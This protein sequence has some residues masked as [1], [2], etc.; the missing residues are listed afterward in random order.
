MRRTLLALLLIVIAGG[1][2]RFDAA[3]RPSE[4]QSK[5]EQSYAIIARTI[6]TN[7][8]YG[9]EIGMED[10]VHWVPGAPVFFSVAYHLAGRGPFQGKPDIPAAYK[11]QAMAG[12]L[13]ILASF[14]LGLLIAGRLAGL[15]GAAV[16]AF[17][18]PLIAASGDLLSEPLG[19][20]LVTSALAMTVWAIRD[21][22]RR[23]WRA[24]L[25]GLLLGATVL[26]RADLALVPLIAAAAVAV[27][28]ALATTG[29]RERTFAGLRSAAPLV[30]A[31]LVVVTPWTI[32]AS[33]QA[34]SFVPLSHG[35]GS[36]LFVGTYL[37]GDGALFATKKALIP[38]T[39][40]RF[41]ELEE[42]KTSYVQ[43]RSRD[44]MKA[45][46]L[47]R[48]EL[49]EEAALK[50]EGFANLRRYALGDPLGF[51]QMMVSKV[52]RL[53]GGYSVGTYGNRRAPVMAYHLAIVAI[54]FAGLLAGLVLA[55]R[56]VLLLPAAALLYISA[57]NAVLVSESR[58]NLTLIPALACA[59]VGGI[60]LTVRELRAHRG[61][62]PDTA[63]AMQ[64]SLQ[65][66]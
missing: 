13:L 54:G 66:A 30:G 32:F 34:G 10:P 41:P 18:P 58:H 62:R 15:L 47:R 12:T 25:A 21:P 63:T 9:P 37:P 38:E 50:A 17:Y 39:V 1:A 59:G 5:D 51:G 31:L 29:R 49:S 40:R 3:S 45:V 6:M 20:L 4:Y 43:Y 65:A 61:R 55:R 11:W 16:V 26:T 19:A 42:G 64:G 2:L 44:V 27:A 52:W 53:W 7:H 28:A 35:G 60:V 8:T 46:A 22:G 23:R 33:T 36:N 24:V 56:R 48:P 57:L 14:A